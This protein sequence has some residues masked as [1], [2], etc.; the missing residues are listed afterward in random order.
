MVFS[1]RRRYLVLLLVL[2]FA[3]LAGACAKTRQAPLPSGNLKVGVAHFTQPIAATDMLAGYT[4]ENTPRIDRKVLNE[5][6]VLLASVLSSNT[7]RGFVGREEALRCSKA[8]AAKGGRSNNQ[9]ALRTWCAVGNCMKVDLLVVP[10]LYE[11]HE[12]EGSAVGVTKPASV[13]MDI[14]VIDVR[15]ETLLSRSRFDEAQSSLSSNLLDA[16]KFFKRGGKWITAADL[17]K[18]G[19]EKAVKE[20][21]L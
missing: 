21:S 16:G 6:D 19:M 20:L 11:Y 15:N 9:A 18:E 4:P 1:T 8:I 17:A 3:L 5:M 12:R 7:K 13:I 2:S 10:Q 14:F